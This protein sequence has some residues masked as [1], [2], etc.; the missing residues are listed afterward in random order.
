[1]LGVVQK[2]FFGPLTN[3]KN[4]GLNDLNVRET[5][6]L[7]PLVA[8]V[9]V[10]GFFPNVFLSRMAESAESVVE[11]YEE[12]KLARNAL[13]KDATEPVLTRPRGGPLE[14]GYPENPNPPKPD[15][16]EGAQALN[17]PAGVAE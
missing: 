7:A 17:Q 1:M 14:V 2:M 4:R 16:A 10:I 15:G 5:L 9:F 8:M 6:A 12:Q 11:R 13:G 3:S